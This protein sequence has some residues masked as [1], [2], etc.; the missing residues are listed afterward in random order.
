MKDD[1]K[2]LQLW[3]MYSP[4]LT[5]TQREITDLYFNYDLSLGEIAEQKGVSRQSISDCL[6][7]C[8]KQLENY[9]EKLHFLKALQDLSTEYSAYMTAVGRWT[10]ETKKNCPAFEKELSVLQEKLDGVHREFGVE[11][12]ELDEGNSIFGQAFREES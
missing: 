1:I 8:R 3:D 6:N 2:F 9:E 4:L 5:A 11:K 7:K 12:I 10:E